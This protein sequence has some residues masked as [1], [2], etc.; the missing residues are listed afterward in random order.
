MAILKKIIEFTLTQKQN[1]KYIHGKFLLKI[2]GES[3]FNCP[4]G[5][6]PFISK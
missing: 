6:I 2:R 4:F 5:H 1:E 3:G